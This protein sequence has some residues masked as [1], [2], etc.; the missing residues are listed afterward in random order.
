MAPA[1]ARLGTALDAA[2]LATGSA[3]AFNVDGAVRTDPGEIREALR[4]QL[5]SAVRW[6]DCVAS[7]RGLGIDRFVEL[8]P[9][10]TLTAMGKRIDPE[11]E[12]VA[13]STAETAATL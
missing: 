10:G 7:M 4:A 9:G 6:V 2:P 13:V 3:Q 1:A 12:W 5:T 11:A 8:G